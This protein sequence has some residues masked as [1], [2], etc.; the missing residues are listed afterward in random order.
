MFEILYKLNAQLIETFYKFLNLYQFKE[1]L[2]L[3]HT[4]NMQYSRI[5]GTSMFFLILSSSLLNNFFFNII[6]ISGSIKFES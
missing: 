2:Q 3:K 5:Q 6:L 1:S 4:K